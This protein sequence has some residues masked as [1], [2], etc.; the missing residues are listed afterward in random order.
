MCVC[1]CMSMRTCVSV[2]VQKKSVEKHCRECERC[3]YVCV[4][5]FPQA[6]LRGQWSERLLVWTY[7]SENVGKIREQF[8]GRCRI[9]NMLLFWGLLYANNLKGASEEA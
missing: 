2:S 5:T 8:Y 6:K 3:D 4:H 9:W 7:D 1:V